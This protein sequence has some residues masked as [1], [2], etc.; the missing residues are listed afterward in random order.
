MTTRTLTTPPVPA[1]KRRRKRR[2]LTRATVYPARRI[3]ATGRLVAERPGISAPATRA[4]P[5]EAAEIRPLPAQ[6]SLATFGN[7]R[8]DG[9]GE[10]G[11]RRKIRPPR[12]EAVSISDAHRDDAGHSSH[13]PGSP[14]STVFTFRP[15]TA[16]V[17]ATNGLMS[18]DDFRRPHARPLS[19]M[20]LVTA[21]ATAIFRS[22]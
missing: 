8:F 3:P 14:P 11:T 22:S 2:P 17:H 18:P 4:H 20:S 9:S 13:T 10:S 15:H 21:P 12:I 19:P 1:T 16:S 7:A 6:D 5:H